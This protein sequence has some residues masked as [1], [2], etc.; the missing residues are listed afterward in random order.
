[1]PADPAKPKK[2]RR[3]TRVWHEGP[4]DFRYEVTH[5]DGHSAAGAHFKTKASAAKAAKAVEFA[6]PET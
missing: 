6:T 2:P 4:G 5:P 1:M 3:Q